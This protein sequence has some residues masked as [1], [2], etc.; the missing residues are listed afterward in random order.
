MG[1]PESLIPLRLNAFAAL[2]RA[3]SSVSDHMTN[4]GLRQL[5]GN[6]KWNLLAL[7]KVLSML[8]DEG[9]IFGGVLEDPP[10][11]PVPIKKPSIISKRSQTSNPVSTS[12]RPTLIARYASEPDDDSQK[13]AFGDQNQ[14]QKHT[15]WFDARSK[16]AREANVH[17]PERRNFKFSSINGR[18][19]AAKAAK[20]TRVCWTPLKPFYITLYFAERQ[21][22]RC[23]MR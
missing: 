8:F 22:Q 17:K 19:H 16:Y 23:W 14:R 4:A 3:I 12:D 18:G 11:P 6:S 10:T 13:S 1:S 5:D 21:I 15:T 2:L 20:S 9:A 7:G